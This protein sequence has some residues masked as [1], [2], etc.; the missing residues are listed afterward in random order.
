MTT[1][2]PPRRPLPRRAGLTRRQQRGASCVW[3]C[4]VLS[5]DTAVSL[6]TQTYQ[7]ADGQDLEWHPR[8]CTRC[9]EAG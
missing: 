5:P 4:I 3:C 7:L 9:A 2:L 1:T 8:G 6:G